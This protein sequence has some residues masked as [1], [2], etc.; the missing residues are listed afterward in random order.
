MQWQ[1]AAALAAAGCCCY[2][3]RNQAHFVHSALA[4]SIH[5]ILHWYVQF[6]SAEY[7]FFF[8]FLARLSI[9]SK[10][11]TTAYAPFTCR[12]QLEFI[13]I[14]FKSSTLN[15]IWKFFVFFLHS[16]VYLVLFCVHLYIFLAFSL[17]FLFTSNL[18]RFV[19]FR[20]ILV[21]P[22]LSLCVWCLFFFLLSID[23]RYSNAFR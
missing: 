16:I 22:K 1:N 7:V 17:P 15:N 20:Q 4:C 2:S 19:L 14:H 23:F 8:I 5:T 3:I 6:S 10:V 9:E 13:R 12:L 21:L 18:L 11:E